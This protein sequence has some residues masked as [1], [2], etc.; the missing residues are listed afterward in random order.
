M[1]LC[2]PGGVRGASSHHAVTVLA[3]SVCA[4][5][6]TPFFAWFGH[7]VLCRAVSGGATC[8][9][10]LDGQQLLTAAL[11]FRKGSLADVPGT[12]VGGPAAAID[13]APQ[14]TAAVMLQ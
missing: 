11:L 1:F 9:T 14:I 7:L 3:A 2:W 13:V 12:C 4:W 8:C 10:S 6:R 5:W